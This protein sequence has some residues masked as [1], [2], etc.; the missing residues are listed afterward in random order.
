M[1]ISLSLAF[2]FFL[3]SAALVVVSGIFLAKSGDV[4]SKKSG[5]GQ[6]W[7]GSLLVAG[8]TSLP[9]LVTNVSAVLIDS[10][11]LAAGNIFG[12]NMLN[13]ATFSI[14]VLIF[15][16]SKIFINLLRLHVWVASVAFFMT[17]I[18]VLLTV[19]GSDF[20]ILFISPAGV[21]III[22]YGF[23]SRFLYQRSLSDASSNI[24]YEKQDHVESISKHWI[25]FFISAIVIFV[26]APIL[27]FTS[28]QIAEITGISEGFMGVL[29]VAIV[30]TLPEFTSAVTSFKIGSPDL[31]VSALFGSNAFNIA[32]LGVA[33]LFYTK[34]SL[35]ASLDVSHLVAGIFAIILIGLCLLQLYQKTKLRLF[36]VSTPSPIMVIFIYILGLFV[37]F[38]LG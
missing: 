27:A 12:A 23:S 20:K 6:V 29:A 19:I 7:V 10:P 8:A 13:M 32:A 31:G 2:L 28:E 38:Q 9:E 15:G 3:I 18:A 26:S 33:D 34:G 14:L 16:G 17:L 35:F 21:I 37:V 36:S 11:K 5:L 4:I 30:T 1:D 24:S 25:L 22:L